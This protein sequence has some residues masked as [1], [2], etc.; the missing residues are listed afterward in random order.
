MTDFRMSDDF[1]IEFENG[2]YKTVSDIQTAAVCGLF[3]NERTNGQ[4]GHFGFVEG[5]GS[6]LW[7]LQQARLTSATLNNARLYANE[8]LNFLITDG[9]VTSVSSDVRLAQNGLKLISTVITDNTTITREF[10]L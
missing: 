10:T 3:F 1:D 6:L 8:G 4:E 7:T 5:E 9:I 2:D